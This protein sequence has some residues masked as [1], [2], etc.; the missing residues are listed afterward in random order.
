MR[1]HRGLGDAERLGPLQNE[2][3]AMQIMKAHQ[4]DLEIGPTI[5]VHVTFDKVLS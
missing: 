4:H 1:Y 2:I 5:A 3:A